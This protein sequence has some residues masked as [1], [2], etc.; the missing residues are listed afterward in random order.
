[1]VESIDPSTLLD[2]CV[3]V[4][5]WSITHPE[6]LVS[7]LDDVLKTINTFTD[8]QD[9]TIMKMASGV[10]TTCIVAIQNFTNMALNSEEPT[11]PDIEEVEQKELEEVIDNDGTS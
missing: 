6:T 7:E 11:E 10:A 5:Q 2:F 9:N 8:N 4:A 3:E 1:M